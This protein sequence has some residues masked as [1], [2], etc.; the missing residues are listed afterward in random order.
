MAE[1]LSVVDEIV[2]QH[3]GGQIA[4]HVAY[5]LLVEEFDIE[6]DVAL[7]LLHPPLTDEDDWDIEVN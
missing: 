6:P 1:T 2:L 3:K 7:N 5:K 4:F